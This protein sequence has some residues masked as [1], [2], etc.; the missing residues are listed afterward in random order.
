MPTHSDSAELVFLLRD[1]LA[2]LVRGEGAD[3]T[4]RQMTVFL[5][6]YLMAGPHTVRGLAADLNVSRPAITR[7]LDRLGEFGL[8][9][10]KPDPSDRRSIFAERTRTG[11]TFLR[12]LGQIM[13]KAARERRAGR[14][15]GH[16]ADPMPK[17]KRRAASKAPPR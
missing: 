16:A 4:A 8:V 2:D 3:M 9:R 14:S 15:A 13:Q 17:A 12:D 11:D 6:V 1:T 5:T 10:R 7:A